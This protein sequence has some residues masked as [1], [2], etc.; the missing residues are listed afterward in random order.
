MFNSQSAIYVGGKW[1]KAKSRVERGFSGVIA[2]LVV[3]GIRVLDL[4]AEKD[5]GASVRGDA[6]LMTGIL[7]RNEL[8]RMQQVNQFV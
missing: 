6:Q 8:H 3:N 4:A 2:G 5:S 7:D 1:N